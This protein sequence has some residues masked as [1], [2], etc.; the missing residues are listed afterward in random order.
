MKSFEN[1]YNTSKNVALNEQ[2]KVF[3]A[4]KAKLLAA[5]KHEYGVKDFNSL[6]EAEKSSYKSMLNEMWNS[7]TGM[8]EKGIAFLNESKAVLT[9]QSTDEQIEKY[10]KKEFK[11]CVENAVQAMA[12]GKECGCCKEIK[13]K[14]EADTKKKLSNK[15]AKQWMYA[16]CCDYIGSKIKSIKF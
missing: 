6:T 11:A 12:S 13:A 14:V 8:T 15:V 5:I 2:Q 3:A 10:F 4:D 1:V 9:E 16:V 7:S